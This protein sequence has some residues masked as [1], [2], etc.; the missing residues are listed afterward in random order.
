M[1]DWAPR[2]VNPILSS[3]VATYPESKGTPLGCENAFDSHV[4]QGCCRLVIPNAIDRQTLPAL[5]STASIF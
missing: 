5:R 3:N 2:L 1:D 4:D